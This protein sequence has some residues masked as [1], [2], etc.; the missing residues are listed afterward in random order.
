M[1]CFWTGFVRCIWFLF[2]TWSSSLPFS[3][4]TML[5]KQRSSLSLSLPAK[6]NPQGVKDILP[7]QLLRSTVQQSTLSQPFLVRWKHGLGSPL[8]RGVC[9]IWIS[10]VSACADTLPL[11]LQTHRLQGHQVTY[12]KWTR[13]NRLYFLAEYSSFALQGKLPV[14]GRLGIYLA[15]VQLTYMLGLLSH[16][17][18][19]F[20]FMLGTFSFW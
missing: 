8:L 5:S 12:R 17:F 14:V 3:C 6:L 4:S 16:I 11:K 7:A 10:R 2:E 1:G 20:Y 15:V 19:L 18:F 13:I 9:S